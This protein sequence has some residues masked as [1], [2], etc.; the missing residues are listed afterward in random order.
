MRD[1]S[2]TNFSGDETMTRV[3]SFAEFKRNIK[4]CVAFAGVSCERARM[5][6]EAAKASYKEHGEIT[7]RTYDAALRWADN[8]F[9]K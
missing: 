4:S 7:E 2:T 5:I 9:W 8:E 3:F 6:R 1:E